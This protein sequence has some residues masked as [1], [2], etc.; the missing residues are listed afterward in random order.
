MGNIKVVIQSIYNIHKNKLDILKENLS[1][2]EEENLSESEIKSIGEQ[3]H[4]LASILSDLHKQVLN[5][6]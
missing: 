2:S 1:K 3:I 5:K 4:I 6:N